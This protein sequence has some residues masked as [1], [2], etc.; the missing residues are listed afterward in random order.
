VKN[1]KLTEAIAILAQSSNKLSRKS[2]GISKTAFS[3]I[4]RDMFEAE[5]F[6]LNARI[7]LD[8]LR[9]GEK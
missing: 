6:I 4:D 3:K 7:T 2:L 8:N 1:K 9:R 5:K